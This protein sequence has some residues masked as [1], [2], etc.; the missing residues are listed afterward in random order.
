MSKRLHLTLACGDY[1]TI[2]ALKEG[3]V[4]PDGIE[5][6]V[7]TD[8]TSDVRHWRMIRNRE[9]DV[10]ELSM[11]NY[12]IARFHG[13][14]FAAIPVFLHRRFRHG[15]V[16]V[17][18]QRG[19][20]NPTDL[21]GRKVGLR[22]FQATNNLWVRGILEHEYGVPHRKLQWFTQDEEEVEFAP[23]KDLS[24]QRIPPR[25]KVERML[26]EGELDAVIHPEVIQ[27]IMD[28]DKRVRRLFD[29]YRELEVEYFNRTGIFPI[30][31]TTALKQE[32]VERHPWVP[33]NLMEAF[34]RAKDLAYQRMENPRRVPLAWFRHAVEEQEEILGKDPWA[35]GLGEANRRNL[36]TLV[37]YSYEQGLI[38]R[39]LSLEELFI[40]ISGKG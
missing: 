24:L 15:F 30:M 7:L 25:Q 28:R 39:R 19:I 10:A 5:L 3:I 6:T 12:M 23:P 34:Q 31:H 14:P 21:I 27:P 2:Y 36:E 1:E 38:G 11:S 22:N 33:L 32:I 26:V 29:N 17:N 13:L 40:G 37:Q 18:A 16:F 4:R 35:Y 9:F 20:E 8:M